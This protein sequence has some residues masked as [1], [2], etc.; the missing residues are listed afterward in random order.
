MGTV[1]A[2]EPES[3]LEWSTPPTALAAAVVGGI[4]LAGAAAL[5]ADGPSRLLVGLAA[6]MLLGLAVLGLRQR[7]RLTIVPG[8]RPRLIVRGLFG[9]A[10]YPAERILRAR[11]VD[12]RRLGR[13][14][15][16]LELDVEQ[17]GD[18]RL[19]I[20]GRWDLGTHPE[21][22]LDAMR[23]HGLVPD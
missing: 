20:F 10:E 16:N 6:A 7:P 8:D 5:A 19:L 1:T 17:H 9:P 14:V 3:R 18:E 21:D 23:A 2:A 12:F 4:A 11:V 13:R 15:P 22:V